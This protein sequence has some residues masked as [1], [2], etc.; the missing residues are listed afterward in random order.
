METAAFFSSTYAE[1][2]V[3]NVSGLTWTAVSVSVYVAF[4]SYTK[5]SFRASFV[6]LL[7]INF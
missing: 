3:V 4:D 7:Y 1:S 2:R 6:K 5:K